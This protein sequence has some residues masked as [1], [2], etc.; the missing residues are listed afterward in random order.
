MTEKIFLVKLNNDVLDVEFGAM[1]KYWHKSLKAVELTKEEIDKRV[2]KLEI[3]TACPHCCK[4]FFIE[5]NLSV[6]EIGKD[7]YD[8]DLTDLV[9]RILDLK[10]LERI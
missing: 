4:E 10:K 2:K 1:R 3:E 8:Y 9:L 6:G 5:H 7:K